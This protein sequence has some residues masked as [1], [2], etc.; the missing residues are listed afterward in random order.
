MS[1]AHVVLLIATTLAIAAIA[2]Y[3]IIIAVILKTVFGRLQTIL[4]AVS[5][6]TEKTAPAGAVIE[7]INR[8]LAAGHEAL[9]ACVQRLRERSSPPSGAEQQGPYASQGPY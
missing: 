9:E 2:V 1:P 6:V 4:A 3:L 5:G 8:D 7:E